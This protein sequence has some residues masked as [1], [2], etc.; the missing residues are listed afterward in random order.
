MNNTRFATA[1]HIL[2]FLAKFPEDWISSDWIAGSIG[3][4]PVIVRKELGLLQEKGW[5]LSRKGKE[6]GFM[7][8]VSPKNLPLSDIYASVKNSE[9]LGKKHQSPNPKCPIGRDMNKNLESLFAE[10]ETVITS[11]LSKKNLQHFVDGFDQ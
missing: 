5:V 3:I 7:L 4:N 6:G 2:S 9:V 11:F 1:I 8:D 10:T